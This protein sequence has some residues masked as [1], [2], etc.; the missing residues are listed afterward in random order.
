Y[1]ADAEAHQSFYA[2]GQ[3]VGF[4]YTAQW[5]TDD[6]LI[7][8]IVQAG[9]PAATAGLGRGDRIVAIGGIATS[10]LRQDAEAYRQALGAVEVGSGA[11]FTVITREG[12]ERQLTMTRDVVAIDPV[13][14]VGIHE[15]GNDRQAGYI[16]FH[17]HIDPALPKLEAAFEQLVQS[18]ADELILD[19]RYN[20]GGSLSVAQ[21]FLSLILGDI[22]EPPIAA[23][24]FWPA[25]GGM[26]TSATLFTLRYNDSDWHR[27]VSYP[28]IPTSAAT[29][30]DLQRVVILTGPSTASA[31]ETDIYALRPYLNV[32]DDDDNVVTLGAGTHGKPVGMN[33]FRHDASDQL[34][35]P[36][37]F[38]VRNADDEGGFFDG[39]AP[40]GSAEDDLNHDLGDP[41]EAMLAA[42][43]AYLR[44]EG[45]PAVSAQ[46]LPIKRGPDPQAMISGWHGV[47]G[48]Q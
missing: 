8:S 23:A 14:I 36:I 42:A 7:L 39:I 22:E 20:G 44:G 25:A 28:L 33:G 37:T 38:E 1:L 34:L 4:G 12:D 19:L 21:V 13:P 3:Y 32:D 48:K 18:G 30:L 26:A 29:D 15:L 47:M 2:A 46:A 11:E 24:G 31:S 41:E 6:H 9:S 17:D 40:D 27:D 5:T 16:A 45:L 35:V 43:L 10:E